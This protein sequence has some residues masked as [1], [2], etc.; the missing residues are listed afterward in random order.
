M[1]EGEEE[2]EGLCDSK[3]H[4]KSF[5]TLMAARNLSQGGT[6][7]NKQDLLSAMIHVVWHTLRVHRR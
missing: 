7:Y 6:K 5:V 2:E 3:V 4:R 1:E